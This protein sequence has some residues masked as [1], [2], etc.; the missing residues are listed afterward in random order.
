MITAELLK[1][2]LVSLCLGAL[3]GLERQWDEENWH[4]KTHLLA[5]LRTFTFWAL[6]GTL[7]G[8]FTQTVHPLFFLTGFIVMAVWIS[9][10]LF[11]KQWNRDGH[12]YTTSAVGLLTY[13]IG[14][15]V[16]WHQEKVALVLTFTVVILLALKPY[17]H[18]MSRRFSREDVRMA[19][20]F[21][22]ITGVILPL[23]P[24]ESWGP[25]QAFNPRMIWM[26][27]V[28]VSG[29]SFG[30][31]VAVRLIGQRMGIALTGILGGV[32]S[33]TATTMAMSR[34]SQTDPLRSKECAL[35]VI[36]A[37]T[38]MLWRVLLLVTAVYSPLFDQL[39]PWIVLMSVPGFLFC[40]WRI[41]LHRLGN[42]ED[43]ASFW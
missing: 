28:L 40:G 13:L 25:F 35:A 24:D 11:L 38:V 19:L 42:S 12:G 14:G 3:I 32:A 16:A 18:R 34:Q 8:Y 30:G 7:C 37:C 5:G 41:W 10:F 17:V 29:A 23:V 2:L 36:L 26:M 22:A 31:Y 33:S 1:A 27:V 21:A 39:L 20:Q 15:L 6:L 4:P 43:A 9:I